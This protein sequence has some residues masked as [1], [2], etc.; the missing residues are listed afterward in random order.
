MSQDDAR[1]VALAVV[2]AIGAAAL[3]YAIRN[4]SSRLHEPPPLKEG[5]IQSS[6]PKRSSL[7]WPRASMKPTSTFYD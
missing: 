5:S 7:T 3:T 6:D 1:L 4:G 2:A